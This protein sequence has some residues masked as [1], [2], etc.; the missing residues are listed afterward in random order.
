MS[1]DSTTRADAL[2]RYRA[3]ALAAALDLPPFRRRAGT[4]EDAREDVAPIVADVADR[5]DDAVAD[6]SRRLDGIAPDPLAVPPDPDGEG[7]PPEAREALVL[8]AERIRRFHERTAPERRVSAGD[9]LAMERVFE[10]FDRVGLYVP[11]GRAAYPSTVLMLAIPARVAGVERVVAV[12]PPGPGGEVGPGVRFAAHLAGVDDLF[13]VGGAQGIASLAFGTST[14][15]RVRAIVGPGNRWVTAA[16]ALV[17]DRVAIDM[18]AGPSEIAI[19][20]D[21]VADPDW[22][23]ADVLA[24][25]EHDPD[26]RALVVSPDPRWLD[27][28]DA[29]LERRLPELATAETIRSALAES[30]AIV[31]PDLELGAEVVSAW[32]PEHLSIVVEDA[33]SIVERVRGSGATFVGAAAPVA[34]GDYVAGPNHTL[35]TGGTAAFRSGLGVEA[36]GRWTSV[37]REASPEV[38]DPLLGAAAALADLEGLPAHAAS[39]RARRARGGG[40]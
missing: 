29:A 1:A 17:A 39:L 40:A 13:A 38:V 3:D 15:P 16:K 28:V 18:P 7:L 37:V 35:P 24:Q 2:A 19:L 4:L 9:G 36:F 22:A 33:E 11:G 34:L 31:V 30:A 12:T 27:A 6:W 5:G 21:R 26:A 25:L 10:P 32:A 23:A 8:A 20:A 14:V